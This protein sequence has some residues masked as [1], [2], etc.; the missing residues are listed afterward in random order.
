MMVKEFSPDLL[1]LY[2]FDSSSFTCSLF[3][4]LPPCKEGAYFPFQ[5]ECKFP[6]A[7]PGN[8]NASRIFSK[9]FLLKQDLALFLRLEYSGTII[10]HYSLNPLGSSD[11]PTSASLVAGTT[12]AYHHTWLIF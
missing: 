4:L 6:E 1:L 8:E 11:L 10:A 12:D 7:C 9:K 5:H 3:S 2:V